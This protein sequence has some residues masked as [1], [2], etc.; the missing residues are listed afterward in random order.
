[1]KKYKS[2]GSDQIP[3]E[4]IQA[5]DEMLL[6]VIQKLVNSIRNKEELPDQWMESINLSIDK[7]GKRNWL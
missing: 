3:S 6:F 4:L 2:P 1:L 5:G 7:K